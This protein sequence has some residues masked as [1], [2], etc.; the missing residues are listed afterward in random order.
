MRIL[1]VLFALLAL[2][3]DCGDKS[4]ISLSVDIP[5]A[6]LQVKDAP[7]GAGVFGSFDL[8]LALGPEASG[9]TT[10]TAGSFSLQS[11]SGA[12]LVGLLTVSPDT[13]SPWLVD[14]G[15]SKTVH[16]K[17][18]GDDVVRADT[19]PG[20]V[21]IVGSVMDTLKGGTDPVT[22]ALLTPDCG[23]AT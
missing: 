6:S 14:K 5:Q 10:V 18:T 19:C 23:P 1:F 7:F 22:S 11:A 4:A 3:I 12:P 17:L 15:A 20:P 13:D 21:R 8:H 2:L 16:F 9:S